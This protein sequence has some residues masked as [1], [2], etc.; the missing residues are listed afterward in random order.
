MTAPYTADTVS[1]VLGYA[2]GAS[3][4]PLAGGANE[5]TSATSTRDLVHAVPLSTVHACA[6]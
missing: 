1:R 4:A 6:A 2:A 5:R 3:G